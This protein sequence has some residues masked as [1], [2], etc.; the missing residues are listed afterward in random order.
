MMGEM[1]RS[2]ALQVK[3]IGAIGRNILPLWFKSCPHTI[4]GEEKYSQLR[5]QGKP[6]VIAVW[7]GRLFLVPYFFRHRN[8]MA[9]IS[10]SQDGDIVVSVGRDWGY[11]ILRGSSSHSIA[12]AWLIMLRELRQG[13]EVIMVPDGPK[14]PNR[15]FKSGAIKQSQET[16]ASIVPF[17]FSCSRKRYAKSWDR[18][19]WFFPF[20]KVVAIYGEPIV[21]PPELSEAEFEEKRMYLEKVLIALDEKADAYFEQTK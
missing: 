10:P 12:K 3:I 16:G 18:F 2:K 17:S 5:K 1:S 7:H 15:K 4:L 8:T 9:F 20:N 14:G 19:L 13:G 11:K 21:I 6:V